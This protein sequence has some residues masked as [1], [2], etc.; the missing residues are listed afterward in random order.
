M[1]TIESLLKSVCH[2]LPG[3]P[4]TIIDGEISPFIPKEIGDIEPGRDTPDLQRFHE[5]F[6][7]V[8]DEQTRFLGGTSSSVTDEI[9]WGRAEMIA[10]MEGGFDHEGKFHAPMAVYKS[11]NLSERELI[12]LFQLGNY[13]IIKDEEGLIE[14]GR[15][16]IFKGIGNGREYHHPT[17]EVGREEEYSTYLACSF[18]SPS[19]A[20]GFNADACRAETDHVNDNLVGNFYKAIGAGRD[21]RDLEGSYSTRQS[22]SARKFGSNFV[23]MTTTLDNVRIFSDWTG[24]SEVYLLDPERVDNVQFNQTA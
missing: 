4:S 12:I 16:R 20:L 5:I 22:I 15:I 1:R 7:E 24:E 11:R 21:F 23:S 3:H 14:Q 13:Q 18:L 9:Y 2:V 19:L 6:P 8:F 10:Q 17:V